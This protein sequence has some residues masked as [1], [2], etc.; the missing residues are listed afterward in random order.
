[1]QAFRIELPRQA[2]LAALTFALA[3]VATF[4]LTGLAQKTADQ[5]AAKPAEESF[6]PQSGQPGKDVVWVPT[7]PEVVEAMLDMAQVK[8]G[9]RLVD[10]GSGDGRIAIAAAKRGAEAM[11]VEYNPKMVA[12]SE[13]NAA[14]EGI[15]NVRFVQGDLFQVDFSDADVVTMYL[16]PMLN[17]KLRPQ[18]LKMKPGT[19]VASH[20]FTMGNWRPDEKRTIS[21]HDALFWVVPA[22]VGGTWR[23]EPPGGGEPLQLELKQEY[24]DLEAQATWGTRPAVV[25]DVGLS[26]GNIRFAIADGQGALFRFKGTAG[27]DG[28]MSGTVIGGDGREQ[29]FTATRV[30]P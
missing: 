17:E 16:L 9:D 19:R 30:T 11:G 21:F 8:A 25:S 27:H 4:P 7:P 28:K 3:G 26:G 5:D 23:V 1:M 6:E 18:L 15:K 14:R 10:L 13:R 12:V 22:Q 2:R 29:P 24:Q 20:Q